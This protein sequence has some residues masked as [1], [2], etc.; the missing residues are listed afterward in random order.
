MHALIELDD[1]GNR[2][3]EHSAVSAIYLTETLSELNEGAGFLDRLSLAEIREVRRV[4]VA[5][6]IEPGE[7][8]FMQ[9]EP[10][11][12]I[13]LIESGRIKT[14][15]TGPTGKEITLAYWPAGH[16]VGGPEVFGGG[17]HMW[18]AIAMQPSRLR[19]MPG[20]AIRALVERIPAFAVGLIEGLVSKGKC[21][22]ALVQMLGT[23]SASE[24]LAQLLLILA[25]LHGRPEGDSLVVDREITHDQLAHI[26]GS[27]RQWVTNTLTRFQR[28]GLITIRRN[29][30][31]IHRPE[32]LTC[33]HP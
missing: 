9:G 26:I 22:S 6:A 15:Y 4:S 17:N 16:F 32:L 5:L 10:H 3:V 28:K 1:V 25:R 24:R 23:R 18:S 19:Y 29:A 20:P 12:G 11:K 14:Y 27:T 21:Y 2:P 7:S 30:I 31:V 33:D 13:Y 8:A